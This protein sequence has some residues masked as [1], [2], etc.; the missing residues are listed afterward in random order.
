MD[1]C[2]YLVVT[3]IRFRIPLIAISNYGKSVAKEFY[4]VLSK[5]REDE[6]INE[7]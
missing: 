7:L 4:I 1:L 6:A 3:A 5:T 2:G